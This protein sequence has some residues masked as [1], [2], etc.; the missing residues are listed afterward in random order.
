MVSPDWEELAERYALP[1]I[2]GR[3]KDYSLFFKEGIGKN[4]IHNE[5]FNMLMDYY[6]KRGYHDKRNRAKRDIHKL[7]MVKHADKMLP[8]VQTRLLRE[9][10]VIEY[11]RMGK[12]TVRNNVKWSNEE[13]EQLKNLLAE[14][15]KPKQIAG[16]LGRSRASIYTKKARVIK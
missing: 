15:R 10:K 9:G 13:V 3:T 2:E 14:G 7:G 1:Y 6:A 11:T 5:M 4:L 8:F 16:I 12:K